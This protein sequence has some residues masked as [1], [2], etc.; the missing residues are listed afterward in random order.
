MKK[1]SDD[2]RSGEQAIR[3]SEDHD[4]KSVSMV[5]LEVGNHA[6][7]NEYFCAPHSTLALLTMGT[8]TPWDVEA[9]RRLYQRDL[10]LRDE[11]SRHAIP[12]A[13]HIASKH[14]KNF[15]FDRRRRT[16]T[17]QVDHPTHRTEP[18]FETNRL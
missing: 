8:S 10:K 9:V 12:K 1:S 4:W 2:D 11:V 16:C 17:G 5:P 13:D 7:I 3:I 6:D 14:M 18:W 15:R